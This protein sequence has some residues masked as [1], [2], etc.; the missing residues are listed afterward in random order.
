[1]YCPDVGPGVEARM[2]PLNE[3]V[4]EPLKDLTD[5]YLS[6]LL[7]EAGLG[8]LEAMLRA[9]AD[10]RRYFVRYARMH[11]DLHLEARSQQASDRALDRIDNLIRAE[12][13]GDAA[14]RSLLRMWF[15][16]KVLVAAASLL[17]GVGLTWGVWN[18]LAGPEPSGRDL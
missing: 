14:Q 3:Q 15:T 17:L 5:A 12:A 2:D 7:D 13:A 18:R 8:E 16:P 1:M 4:P 6:G 9:D 11:T 10:A